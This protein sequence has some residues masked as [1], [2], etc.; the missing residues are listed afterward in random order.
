MNQTPPDPVLGEGPGVD[1]GGP[2]HWCRE[3]NG[4]PF[5]GVGPRAD[6]NRVCQT[7]TDLGSDVSRG[8]VDSVSETDP[9]R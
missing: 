6:R 8:S 3:G 9:N 7:G 1:G 2:D 5:S 4:S